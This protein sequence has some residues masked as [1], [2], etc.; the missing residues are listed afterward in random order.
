MSESP[1]YTL[2]LRQTKG[3]RFSIDRHDIGTFAGQRCY[4]NAYPIVSGLTTIKK[5]E[6]HAARYVHDNPGCASP[7]EGDA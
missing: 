5:A 4:V 3:G 1:S 2:R 7:N 6:L